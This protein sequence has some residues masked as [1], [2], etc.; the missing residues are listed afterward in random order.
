MEALHLVCAHCAST[1]RIPRDRLGDGPKCGS[2]REPLLTRHPL[3]LT[4]VNFR[5]HL[6]KDDLPLAVD[7]WAPWCGPCQAMAPEFEAAAETLASEARLFKVNT[8]A[9]PTIAT[10][11]SIRGIPTLILFKSGREVA[12]QSGAMGRGDI[13]RWIRTKAASV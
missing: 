4:S 11:F 9:E 12:R 6:E 8:D 7:F 5:K 3:E 2:C 13:T 10:Q 1:N